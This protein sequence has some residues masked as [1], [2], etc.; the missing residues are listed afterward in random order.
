MRV[1]NFFFVLIFL[2]TSSFLVNGLDLNK[3]FIQTDKSAYAPNAIQFN[4]DNLVIDFSEPILKKKKSDSGVVKLNPRF[5]VELFHDQD[6]I[7]LNYFRKSQIYDFTLK[8]IQGLR[9]SPP[10]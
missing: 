9:L 3:G 7:F 4:D 6:L 8:F 1:I 5:D 2:A 10:K